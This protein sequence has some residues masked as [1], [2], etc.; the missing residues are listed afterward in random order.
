MPPSYASLEEV[1][2]SGSL[3]ASVHEDAILGPSSISAGILG[4]PA[5]LLGGTRALLMQ[6]ADGRVAAGVLDHSSF[7]ADPY[8]RLARTFQVMN[9]IAFASPERSAAAARS[10]RRTHGRVRGIAP[11]GE[12]YDASDPELALWVHATLVDTVLAIERRYLGELN[13]AM[14]ET[15]YQE[16]CLLAGP[17]GI[18]EELLPGDLGAFE[19]YV[20]DRLQVL[21]GDGSSP[22]LAWWSLEV[23]EAVLDPP[24]PPSLGLLAPM[25]SRMGGALARAVTIDLGPPSLCRAYGLPSRLDPPGAVLVEAF[26]RMSR[27]ASPLIPGAMRYPSN[28]VAITRRLAS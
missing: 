13:P 15:F 8:G 20:A 24:P 18:S 6:L 27:A 4:H 12:R 21:L 28:L 10:L 5:I 16:T 25:L 11:D 9:E 2:T 17:L 23:A 22:A 14:R 1:A 7:K 26:A 19:R 3:D